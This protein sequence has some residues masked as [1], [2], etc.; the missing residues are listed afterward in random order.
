[1]KED[2]GNDGEPYA[3]TK[4]VQL[5]CR[6]WVVQCDGECEQ[7]IDQEGECWIIH[8]DSRHG[9]EDTVASWR[10]MYSADGCSVFCPDDR[11]EDAVPSL[12][13]PRELEAAGQLRLPGVLT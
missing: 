3:D 1:M 6:C 7:V 2:R 8:H 10:W 12:P 13:T 9:A 5:G 11:T 4:P